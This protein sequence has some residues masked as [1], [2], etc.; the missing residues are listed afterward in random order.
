V[1]DF[2]QVPSW[3]GFV[4]VAFAIDLYS[5]AIVGWQASVVKDTAFVEACL[6]MALWRRDHAGHTV[7]PGMVHHSDYAEENAK[8]R[9]ADAARRS[10]R[11]QVYSSA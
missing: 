10:H 6:K 11:S 8:P 7:Q 3:G 1:T 4:Y 2:R 5:R 9:S